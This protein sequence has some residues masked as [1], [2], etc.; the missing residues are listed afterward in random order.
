MNVYLILALGLTFYF[1]VPFLIIMF[2]KNKKASNVLMFILFVTFLVV[3]FLGIYCKVSFLD[4]KVF[5]NFD[6][7]GDWF[8]KEI[9]W[10]L[11]NI[12]KFDFVIN[13]IMLLPVGMVCRFLTNSKSIW[14]RI[15][16]LISVSIVS[17]FLTEFGQFVLPI[18]R[19]VQLSDS[20]LNA[21]SVIIGGA[22]AEFYYLLKRL[23]FKEK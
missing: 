8:N 5:I 16:I 10:S 6:F 11:T 2:V 3:L 7:S 12:T 18:P 20:L 22:V 17:G 14:I 19:G 9:N 15:I 21:G 1:I 23:I 13:I 4:N